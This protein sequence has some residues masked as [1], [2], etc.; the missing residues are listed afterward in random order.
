M[1]TKKENEMDREDK[2][3]ALDAALMQIERQYGKGAV[4]KLGDPASAMNV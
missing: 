2:M 3:K 4:M 1:F